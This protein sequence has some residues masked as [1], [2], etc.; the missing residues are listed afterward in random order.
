MHAEISSQLTPESIGRAN[1]IFD[2]AD[3]MEL[4]T[5]FKAAIDELR[6][7]L[8]VYIEETSERTNENPAVRTT[9]LLR[10]TEML[11]ALSQ[12]QQSRPSPS[13]QEGSFFDRLHIVMDAYSD[14][15]RS[16]GKASDENLAK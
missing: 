13:F 3:A 9:H 2:D 8:W 12:H 11:R 5:D 1:P 10:A 7:I 15:F 4:L 14:D 16:L 6:T